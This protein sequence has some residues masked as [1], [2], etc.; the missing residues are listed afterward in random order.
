RTMFLAKVAAVATA[1]SLTVLSLNVFPGLAAP[2]AFSAALTMPPPEYDGAIAPVKASNM[3]SVLDRDMQAA[4]EPGGQLALGKDAG[5][6]IGV[7][8]HGVRSVFTYGTAHPDSIF[9]IGSIT[10]TFTGLL[11]ARM[12]AQG[13]VKLNEPVRELLPPGTAAKPN[14]SEITLLDLA[15]Q[16]SGLPGLPDNFKPVD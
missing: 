3:Q 9:E 15:T 10:K 7:V 13:K 2:F 11:L 1:L 4:R 8:E 12:A 16:H 5:L 14:G 6:T